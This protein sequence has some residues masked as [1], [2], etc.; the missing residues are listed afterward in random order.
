VTDVNDRVSGVNLDPALNSEK[1]N[2]QF[3]PMT[4]HGPHVVIENV[5]KRFPVV[6]RGI[7]LSHH[8]ESDLILDRVSF[9]VDR[10]EFVS[11]LGPSGCGKTSLLRILAGLMQPSSGQVNIGGDL[12]NAPRHESAMVFQGIGLLNWRTIRENAALGLQLKLHRKLTDEEWTKVDLYLKLVGLEKWA[13]SY[14]RQ[15]SGGM[16]QRVGIARALA[17]EPDLLL[18]DEPFGALD[19]QTRL[20]LQEELLHLCEQYQSTVIFVTHDIEEAICLSD[21]IVVMASQPGRIA[22]IVDVNL[23]RPRY[24]YDIRGMDEF[25]RLRSSL[26][27]EIRTQQE[28]A[29]ASGN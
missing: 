8:S 16:Q 6:K 17:T 28:D 24:D 10:L 4:R 12:V 29:L 22:E 9:S 1:M 13:T 26:W 3:N 25:T 7:F 21:R 2:E 14:P 11:I 20:I 15:I 19:A 18:M 27:A 5:S 23:P